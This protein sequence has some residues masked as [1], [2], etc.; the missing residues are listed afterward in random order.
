MDGEYTASGHHVDYARQIQNEMNRD[1]MPSKEEIDAEAKKAEEVHAEWKA[2]EAVLD[3]L[4]E[5]TSKQV[6]RTVAQALGYDKLANDLQYGPAK[7]KSFKATHLE[8]HEKPEIP[9]DYRGQL[10][11]E[12]HMPPFAVN[13]RVR[14]L[15]AQA[16]MRLHT[17]E[18]QDLRVASKRINPF[19]ANLAVAVVFDDEVYTNGTWDAVFDDEKWRNS[20][21]EET[22]EEYR[23]GLRERLDAIRE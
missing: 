16:F 9:D 1:A 4:G 2:V 5:S 20:F 6:V 10:P 19:G 3:R 11:E 13:S 21:D 14:R 17:L 7:I 8:P 18:W 23:D 22:R 12:A 15:K